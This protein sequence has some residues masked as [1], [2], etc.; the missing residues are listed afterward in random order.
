ML[1]EPQAI[2]APDTPGHHSRSRRGS[3]GGGDQRPRVVVL[4]EHWPVGGAPFT[5]RD[6]ESMVT[7]QTAG[8]LTPSADVHIV[9]AQ[10]A[11]A[12]TIPDGAFT[13]HFLGNTLDPSV[14]LRRS[15]LLEALVSS[16]SPDRLSDTLVAEIT[17]WLGDGGDLWR[18]GAAVV[19]AIEPDVVMVSGHLHLGLRSALG[20]DTP[21]V[22]LPLCARPQGLDLSILAPDLR[23]ASAVV[24]TSEAERSDVSCHLGPD[25]PRVSDT[26]MLVAVNPSVTEQPPAPLA[27]QDYVLVLCPSAIDAATRPAELARLLGLRFTEHPVVVVH[28]DGLVTWRRCQA[29]TTAAVTSDTDLWRLMAW[30]R[31]TVDLRPD[32]LLA[33]HCIESMLLGT[34]VVVP[35]DSRAQQHAA[36][37]NGGLWYGDAA[38]LTSCVEV[39]LEQGVGSRV[40]E[41]GRRYATPRYGSSAT[42][43]DE[44]TAAVGLPSRRLAV[45]GQ[46]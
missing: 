7:R 35:N 16:T 41:Q 29:Q 31:C 25:G 46:P 38:E 13:V 12:H 32:R 10:G 43:V 30:A 28:D 33:L 5:T 39:L 23:M 40:G 22:S 14:A 4:T 20:P 26:G 6:V 21:Y 1:I 36:A 27:A 45:L 19:A 8:A 37:S 44:V 11:H 17:E 9:T 3:T 15:F 34:P 2:V 24:T 42:F 18:G